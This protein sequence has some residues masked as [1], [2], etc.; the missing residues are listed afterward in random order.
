LTP[1][2]RGDLV[3]RALAVFWRDLR[4]QRALLGLEPGVLQARVESAVAAAMRSNAVSAA[5]WRRLPAVLVAGEARR[6]T[7]LIRSAVDRID[8]A[9]PPF[10]V[11]DIEWPT[12][13]TLS[14]LTFHVC[15][16]RVDVLPDGGV[17]IIDYKTGRATAARAWFSRRPQAPQLGLYAVAMGA[18]APAMPVR[19]VAY[20]QLKQGEQK[21]LGLAADATAWP[22]LP[23]PSALRGAGLADWP[24]VEI[25]WHSAL[26]QLTDEIAAGHAAVAPRDPNITCRNCGLQPLCRIGAWLADVGRDDADV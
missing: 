24:A 3:H 25:R 12:T 10:T 2:E 26:G 18:S 21:A 15:L 8:R 16:D 22:G 20:I 9:R 4:D 5:R 1:I 13:V 23:E 14:G 17:A 7:E 19:A 6:M 11:R